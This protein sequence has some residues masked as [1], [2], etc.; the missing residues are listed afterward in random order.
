MMQ[1]EHNANIYELKK[2]GKLFSEEG[3]PAEKFRSHV[4]KTKANML[5]MSSRFV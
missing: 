5:N 4:N 2:Y 3:T 1:I